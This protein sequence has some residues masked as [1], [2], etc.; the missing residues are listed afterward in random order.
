M[1]RNIVSS[2]HTKNG[3]IIMSIIL[4]LGCSSIFRKV[5]NETNCLD[6]RGPDLDELND[7][8]FQHNE[9]CYK[10]NPHSVTCNKDHK[11]VHI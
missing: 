7:K 8:V 10:F 5:C 1:L 11:Q 2:M 9:N 4:G 3:K 6:F